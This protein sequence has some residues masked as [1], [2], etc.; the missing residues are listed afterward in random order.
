MQIRQRYVGDI[1]HIYQHWH[2]VSNFN[3][4]LSLN[5]NRKRAFLKNQ[6]FGALC[7][8]YSSS[9]GE[10]LSRTMPLGLCKSRLFSLIA[11]VTDGKVLGRNCDGWTSFGK[12]MGTENLDRDGKSR[13]TPLIKIPISIILLIFKSHSPKVKGNFTSGLSVSYT[14]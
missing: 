11:C 12:E 6:N 5:T 7:A 2:V 14:F 4:R 9:C 13:H 10:L 3:G 1:K 8:P